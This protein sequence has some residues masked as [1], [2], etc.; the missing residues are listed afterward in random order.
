M[1]TQHEPVPAEPPSNE[2]L[3][4]IMLQVVLYLVGAILMLILLL[5]IRRHFTER[6]VELQDF[7][8]SRPAHDRIGE[9]EEEDEVEPLL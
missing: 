2:A 7:S 3:I 6:A 4:T 9:A 8:Q 1:T 5:R